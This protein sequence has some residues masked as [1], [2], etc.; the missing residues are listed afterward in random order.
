MN[1]TVLRILYWVLYYYIGDAGWEGE[2]I[3]YT[4]AAY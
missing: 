3:P 1:T 4:V 2:M